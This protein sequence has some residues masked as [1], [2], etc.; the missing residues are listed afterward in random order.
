MFYLF[1]GG[2]A[3]SIHGSV[4]LWYKKIGFETKTL[5][6]S[7]EPNHIMEHLVEPSQALGRRC[8]SFQ[9]HVNTDNISYPQAVKST[10]VHIVQCTSVQPR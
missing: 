10:C 9:G 4:C 8:F 7:L 5:N 2:G 6:A 3:T 1:L